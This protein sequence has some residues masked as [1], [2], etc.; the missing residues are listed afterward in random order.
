VKFGPVPIGRVAGAILAH[1]LRLEGGVL[2]KGRRLSEA[3]AARIADAGYERV[4]VARPEPGDVT[5]DA[6]AAAVG[7]AAAGPGLRVTASYTGRCNLYAEARGLLVL[8]GDRIER[9]NRVDE[10]ITLATL[11]PHTLAPQDSMVATVKVIPFA[12]PEAILNAALA[13]I[14]AGP[15]LLRLAPLKPR[16]AGLILTELPGVRPEVL[17]RAAESQRVRLERLG[18][19][20]HRE[21]RCPHEVAAVGD[22]IR[23]LRAA[24]CSPILILGA[25][26]I[27]DRGD[28]V[29]SAVEA[30][31]G[32]ILHL[33]MPV[34][35][36]NLLLLAQWG[37]IPVLGVP[38]CARS[39]KPSGYDWVLARIAAGEAVTGS[40]L[41]GMGVGGLL[42]EIPSRPQPREGDLREPELR[43]QA[44]HEARS[45]ADLTS[46]VGAVILAAGQSQR[47]GVSNKLL[48]PVA[49]VP[50]IER[51]ADAVLQAVPSA[52]VV[53][54]GHDPQGVRSAL[55]GR[56]VSFAHNPDYRLGMS[57]SLRVGLSTL[58]GKV[59]AALIC[60]GD[61]PWVS[62]QDITALVAAFVPED[63]RICVPV[64]DRKR[65]N[66]ILWPARFFAAMRAVSGDQGAR[67]LLDEYAEEIELVPVSGGGVNV[68]IDTPEAL[69]AVGARGY[70]S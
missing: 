64:Y 53:V 59:D 11:A 65:G 61:M 26:A 47:M 66:P 12:V 41:A 37:E 18:S 36:G 2:K 4:V 50:M 6:A 38:G 67:R 16:A 28:V 40:E 69:R 51:V 1:T 58:E 44:R 68:D 30:V 25:S 60:L 43:G 49:G 62:P 32:A 54:T 17:E 7:E 9:F 46:R 24:G 8:D 13:E 63:P 3:D 39:L 52:V 21:I 10:S 15:P 70:S 23:T 33:G 19:A 5:E 48:L 57:T 20:L 27:V 42:K 31:G 35:P 56:A 34:D 14:R 29:P 55:S 45:P 22:A